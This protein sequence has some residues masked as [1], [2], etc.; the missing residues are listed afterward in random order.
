MNRPCVCVSVCVQYVYFF[1]GNISQSGFESVIFSPVLFFQD[2]TLAE[3]CH[4]GISTQTPYLDEPRIN[5]ILKAS[6]W[7]LL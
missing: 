2:C 3:S 7:E 5:K 4:V 6:L 1:R